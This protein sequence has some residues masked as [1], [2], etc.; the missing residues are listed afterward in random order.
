M[1]VGKGPLIH[2]WTRSVRNWIL[3]VFLSLVGF[4][5]LLGIVT[6]I[7]PSLRR[8]MLE[9]TEI[10][11]NLGWGVFGVFGGSFGLYIAYLRSVAAKDA[12]DA[13]LQESKT[14]QEKEE[15]ERDHDRAELQLER[16]TRLAESFSNAMEQLGSD[17][18]AVRIGGIYSLELIARAD[19]ERHASILTIL[20]AKVKEI[21]RSDAWVKFASISRPGDPTPNPS[22]TPQ[23]YLLVQS[24]R[25][26]LQNCID[27]FARRDKKLDPEG[28]RVLLTG[29]PFC[30]IKF[31]GDGFLKEDFEGS[32]FKDV[33][34]EAGD[35]SEAKFS[36]CGFEGVDFKDVN[37]TEAQ[38]SSRVASSVG[39]AVLIAVDRF[40]GVRFEKVDA[41]HIKFF[42]YRIESCVFRNS[43]MVGTEFK[44]GGFFNTSIVG[45]NMKHVQFDNNVW[46]AVT[47]KPSE[48][49]EGP[50]VFDYF[51]FNSIKIE[52]SIFTRVKLGTHSCEATFIESRFDQVDFSTSD[53]RLAEMESCEFYRCDVAN[54]L[55]APQRNTNP[56]KLEDPYNAPP[57]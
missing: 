9:W 55:V 17:K 54:A 1:P 5:L 10:A 51:A 45:C 4:A 44:G 48:F 23:E 30:G 42:G 49:P 7:D 35:F 34:F 56:R 31:W 8:V 46:N 14:A 25:E 41:R 53:L 52:K 16:D 21:G 22:L 24:Q 39:G 36:G 26:E 40:E 38:F 28:Y 2:E 19:K 50:A 47:I 27:F 11:R 37:L 18:L 57:K 3:G 13:A 33:S 20:R 15:R 12:A 29:I 6:L 43:D 32:S